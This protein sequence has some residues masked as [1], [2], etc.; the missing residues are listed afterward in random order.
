M[1]EIVSNLIVGVL[2]FIICMSLYTGKNLY[3]NKWICL[4]NP[5]HL[6]NLDIQVK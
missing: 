4:F 3:H 2:V 1:E 5:L 6:L